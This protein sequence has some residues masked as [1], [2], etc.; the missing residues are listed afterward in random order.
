MT[1][2]IEQLNN[3]LKHPENLN[4][5]F[6]KAENSFSKSELFNYCC[7]LANEGGG[8][9]IFGIVP[10]IHTVSGTKLYEGTYNMLSNEILQKLGIRVDVEEILHPD[11]RVLIFHIP[12]HYVGKPIKSDGIYYMRAGESLVPMDEQTLKQ[13]LTQHEQDFSATLIP[14]LQLADLDENAIAIFRVRRAEKMGKSLQENEPL[15]RIL[16]DAGLLVDGKC[17]FACLV[18]LGR[19]DKIRQFARH[20]EIIFE[21]RTKEGQIHHDFRKEWTAPYFVAHNEIWE[22]INARNLRMP[23]QEGF[24]QREIFAFD[25]KVCREAVNNA[26]AHRDYSITSASIIIHASPAELSVTSPG[27]LLPGITPENIIGKTQWRNRIIADA[28]E[29]TRLV[30]RSG[31][32]VDDIFN[33]TIRQ[34]KGSPSFGGTDAHEVCIHI[35]A[36]VRDV[37]FVQFLERL[38]DERQINFLLDEIVELE[39]LRENHTLRDVR[40]KEKFLQLGVIERVGKTR[41]TMYIL[42]HGYYKHTEKLGE[43]TRIKGLSREQKKALILEHIKREGQGRMSEFLQAFSDLKNSDVHNILQELKRSG[44]IFFEGDNKRSGVWK[45]TNKN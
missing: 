20:S 18:L 44:V 10:L 32:G 8:E 30:E 33:I 42:S 27:G 41:G 25:E 21:W 14:E 4:L 31:Q 13:K 19:A 23:F 7:A 39:K 35:P 34:G 38:A 45:L 26:I 11:G 28:L 17:T 2:S 37:G 24:I 12:A 29:H 22:T 40:F 43:Y 5:E 6:K 16:S 36:I 15:D 3:W 9:L 1:T